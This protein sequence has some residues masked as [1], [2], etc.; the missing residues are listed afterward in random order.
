MV[1]WLFP[2]KILTCWFYFTSRFISDNLGST[3]YSF[4]CIRIR[5][6]IVLIKHLLLTSTSI[7]NYSFSYLSFCILESIHVNTSFHILISP[8][9]PLHAFRIPE[10][11]LCQ[12]R[13]PNYFESPN[14][15]VPLPVHVSSN[16]GLL[17]Y[18]IFRR[19]F[20]LN[21][22]WMYY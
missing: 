9:T 21:K 1:T 19:K 18:L 7:D 14:Q 22:V 6:L 20:Y 15:L 11:H 16:F 12:M 13:T 2:Y 3:A 10:M 8:H 4:W 17:S 5:G